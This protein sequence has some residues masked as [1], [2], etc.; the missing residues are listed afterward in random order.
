PTSVAGSI[1]ADGTITSDAFD[2]AEMYYVSG[3]ASA[4]D[5]VKI[6][7]NATATVEI[8]DGVEYDNDTIGVVSTKPGFLLGWEGDVQVA[9]AGRVPTKVSVGN[10]TITAG[11]RLTTSPIPG[12]A[13]KATRPGQIIGIAL[14]D[15]NVS[16]VIEV[17]IQPGFDMSSAFAAD[18]SM[19]LVNEYGSTTFSVSAE[20]DAFF[21]GGVS[22]TSFTTHAAFDL[23]EQYVSAD[24]LEPGDIVVASPSGNL[25]IQ[26]SADA[27]TLPMGIISTA[28]GFT[29]GAKSEGSYPVALAGRVPTKVSTI[30]GSIKAGDL[31]APTDIPG[32]AGK[33]V[34]DGPVVGIALESYEG[35]DTGMIEVFVKS[36]WY[37]KPN[38]TPAQ[39]IENNTYV[40]NISESSPSVVRRGLASI[41]SGAVK[42]H[43]S[44]ETLLGYPFVQV[45]PRG[46]I[47]G[48]WSTDNYSDTGFDIILE[49]PQ[50]F[51][52][53]FGWEASALSGSTM[54]MMSD[55]T[56]LLVD[57]TTGQVIVQ[58]PEEE[59]VDDTEIITDPDVDAPQVDV[60][61]DP[62]VVSE[63]VPVPESAPEE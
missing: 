25:M 40:T 6:T 42:V 52:V 27:N 16:G 36:V 10:G 23:A 9:L 55:G 51:D 56:S 22:A 38:Q 35:A 43:V 1:F 15:A 49:Q 58:E 61:S 32:V 21:L 17:F 7:K 59:V 31:L 48:S 11:D 53:I 26:R 54:M 60:V 2:L 33:A 8:T 14:E 4:G 50:T 13:M 29:L 46:L 39:I 30:N 47:V 45:T 5:L 34:E 20:G 41:E 24:T 18:G 12:V 44:F 3:T 28:P 19:T 63:E 62:T 57:P 37:S